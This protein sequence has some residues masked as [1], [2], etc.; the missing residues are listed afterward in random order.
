VLKKTIFDNYSEGVRN[1]PDTGFNPFAVMEFCYFGGQATNLLTELAKHA[2][3]YEG[4][5]VGKL[6]VS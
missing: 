1:V 2:A 6:L 5:H 4:V 3:A